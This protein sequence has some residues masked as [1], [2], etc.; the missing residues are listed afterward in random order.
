MIKISRN[1]I[2]LGIYA[3]ISA[4]FFLYY[5]FPSE[6]IKAYLAYQFSQVSP[7]SSVTIERVSPAFPPGI[8]LYHVDL[9]HSDTV[10]GS[11]DNIKIMPGI[12]SLFR[13]KTTLSFKGN[14]YAGKLSGKAEIVS[15]SPLQ[16]VVADTTLAG[17]QLKQIDVIQDISGHTLAGT[18][19]GRFAFKSD[20]RN[21]NL[22]GNFALSNCEVEFASPIFNQGS[23]TFRDVKLELLLNNQTLNIQKCNLEGLQM[24]A[25]ISGSVV[26]N[27]ST[28]KTALNLRGTIKPHHG[29]WAQIG[30]SLP[31]NLLKKDKSGNQGF[32]FKIRGTLDAPEFAFD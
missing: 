15:N 11:I 30:K 2:L 1:R 16:Q 29:L 25:S 12:L 14:A 13:S 23:L 17:I 7:K 27:H 3:I 28:G 8:R 20:A 31:V 18:L 6:S 22:R 21:Q 5:L 26:F 10:W 24:D 19:N 4:A 9:Y 32:A